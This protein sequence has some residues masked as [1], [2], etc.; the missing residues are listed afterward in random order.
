MHSDDNIDRRHG[1]QCSIAEQGLGPLA[2]WQTQ[3]ADGGEGG[4]GEVGDDNDNDVE[5][6]GVMDEDG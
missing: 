4:E 6:N 2:W 3:A 5:E 1:I